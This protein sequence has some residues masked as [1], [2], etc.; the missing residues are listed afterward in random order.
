M[1]IDVIFDSDDYA[2]NKH[3]NTNKFTNNIFQLLYLNNSQFVYINNIIEIIYKTNAIFNRSN[4]C[5]T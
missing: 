3:A 5:L 1:R 4:D 2:K